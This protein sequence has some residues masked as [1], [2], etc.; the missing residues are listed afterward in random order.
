MPAVGIA[1]F[2]AS[3][4]FVN[5]LAGIQEAVMDQT[6]SRPP[7]SDYDIFWCKF[8]FEKCFGASWSKH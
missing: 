2:G 8:G 6:G 5:G 3:H 7:N 1:V 4:R